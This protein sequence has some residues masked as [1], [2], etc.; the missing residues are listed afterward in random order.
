MK[1]IAELKLFPESHSLNLGVY[2]MHK[3]MLHTSN[4]NILKLFHKEICSQD[5]IMRVIQ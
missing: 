2:V 3:F 4:Q 5:Y 1:K